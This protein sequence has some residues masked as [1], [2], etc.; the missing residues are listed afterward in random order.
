LFAFASVDGAAAAIEELG[1][2]YGRHSRAARALAEEHLD[3]RR[4]L[5]RLLK[6][7]DAL[8]PSRAGVHDAGE[9][10]LAAALAP[11]EVT[12]V[13]RRP[14]AYRSSSPMAE[15]DVAL[16]A[17]GTRRL[18]LKDLGRDGLLDE[19]RRAKPAFLHDPLREIETYRRS[20]ATARLGTPELYGAVADESTA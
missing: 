9:E 6:A 18:L 16:R 3:S 5:R 4:V 15:V 20:L 8:P 11:L 7:L 17:G 12:R 19:A 13:R 1:R 10:E 14:F 2:D